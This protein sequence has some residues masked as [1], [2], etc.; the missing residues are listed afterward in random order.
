MIVDLPREEIAPI[1]YK[2]AYSPP[3]KNSSRF[4]K[5]VFIA[6][7]LFPFSKSSRKEAR[8]VFVLPSL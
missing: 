8:A 6:A 5:P 7:L 3:S 1:T 2:P 4:G